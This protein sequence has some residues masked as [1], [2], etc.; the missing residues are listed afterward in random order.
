MIASDAAERWFD[1]NGARVCIASSDPALIAPL[2]AWLEELSV[3]PPPGAGGFIVRVTRETPQG[4]PREAHL[5]H[6]GPLPEGTLCR[7]YKDGD[8]RWLVV[9]ERLAM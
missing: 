2:F 7:I 3:P 9:P 6:D 1:F 5:L 8:T 4:P